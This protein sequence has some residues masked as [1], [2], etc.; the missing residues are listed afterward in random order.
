MAKNPYAHPL[1]ASHLLTGSC[2]QIKGIV[3]CFV[4][5]FYLCFTEIL[6]PLLVFHHAKHP[7]RRG[8]GRDGDC[9]AARVSAAHSLDFL[10]SRLRRTPPMSCYKSLE[11][12]A[13]SVSMVTTMLSPMKLRQDVAPFAPCSTGTVVKSFRKGTNATHHFTVHLTSES[14]Y[15]YANLKPKVG[16][17][18]DSRMSTRVL[19]H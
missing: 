4:S 16:V 5:I 9:S 18:L 8:G 14:R 19:M 15:S 2:H 11:T 13:A 17:Y 12:T 3:G 6:N 1:R 7:S 10:L